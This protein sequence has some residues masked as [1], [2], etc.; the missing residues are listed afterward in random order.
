MPFYI[1][2][3]VTPTVFYEGDLPSETMTQV[4]EEQWKVAYARAMTA[5]LPLRPY[6]INQECQRRIYAVA[7]PN[8]QQ[9]MTAYVTAGMASDDE[10]DAFRAVLTWVAAMREAARKL[11]SDMDTTYRDD[12]HWPECSAAVIAF[13]KKL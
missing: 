11:V 1:D 4:S 6:D 10:K 5:P 9:N 7:S 8:T 12:S 2:R 13:A 3:T